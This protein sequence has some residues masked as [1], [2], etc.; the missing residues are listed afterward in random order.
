[1]SVKSISPINTSLS[2]AFAATTQQ[3]NALSMATAQQGLQAKSDRKK[4]GEFVGNV[5]YGQIFKQMQQSTFKTK[6]MSGGRG[7]EAF[8]GQLSMEIAKRLGQSTKNPVTTKIYNTMEKR[9]H[10]GRPIDGTVA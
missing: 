5:F 2:S 9:I 6:Y 3:T 10:H 1:M 4:V 7:E 8:S